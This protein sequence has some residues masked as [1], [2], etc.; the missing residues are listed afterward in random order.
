MVCPLGNNQEMLQ[1]PSVSITHKERNSSTLK[2]TIISR[3]RKRK[4]CVAVCKRLLW[5]W[6][7]N[8]SKESIKVECP[9]E[10]NGKTLQESCVTVTP[11]EW[12]NSIE[13]ATE[14]YQKMWQ[15]TQPNKEN[16]PSM[17]QKETTKWSVHL[18]TMELLQGPC[19]VIQEEW[20][21]FTEKMN[22]KW[23]K[24]CGNRVWQLG[25]R[26]RV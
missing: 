20:N 16:G 2:I 14:I 4:K 25:R 1:G 18:K 19:T 17:T 13:K 6:V 7:N 9:L 10:D 26:Q 12:E 5:E 3:K 22:N 24:I 8:D 11:E 23:T 21:S 15:S